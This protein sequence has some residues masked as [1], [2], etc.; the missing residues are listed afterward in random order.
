LRCRGGTIPAPGEISMAHD[1][2]KWW[3]FAGFELSFEN[4]RNHGEK[5]P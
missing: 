2:V 5:W 3:S 4:A 1:G